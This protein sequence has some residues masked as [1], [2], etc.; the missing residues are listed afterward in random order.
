VIDKRKS[1]NEWH[2]QR[3]HRQDAPTFAP[4]DVPLNDSHRNLDSRQYGLF[5]TDRI[6]FNEH[7]QTILG[8]REV[9]LD[10]KA[11][12]S[13]GNQAATPSNTCSCPRPR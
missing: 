6:R 4:T 1:V 3:Q 8:G 7:W 9:R 5:V 12:D 2:R 11:F 13:N 10:E